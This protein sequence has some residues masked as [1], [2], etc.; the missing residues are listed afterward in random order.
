M[1][2]TATFADAD[3]RSGKGFAEALLIEELAGV[4]EMVVELNLLAAVG[5]RPAALLPL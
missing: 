4:C 2:G 3:L 5:S 1:D